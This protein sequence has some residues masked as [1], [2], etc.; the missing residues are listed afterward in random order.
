MCRL[1]RGGLGSCSDRRRLGGRCRLCRILVRLG[2]GG[3]WMILG[4]LVAA[5]LLFVWFVVFEF[6]LVIINNC[7]VHVIISC[8]HTMSI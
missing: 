2:G 5:V 4:G 6:V 3:L 7:C 1:P 8:E